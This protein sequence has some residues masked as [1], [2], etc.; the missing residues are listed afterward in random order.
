MLLEIH[1]NNLRFQVGDSYL[2]SGDIGEIL[3]PDNKIFKYN[4]ITDTFIFN[5]PGDYT[6]A[7]SNDT[8]KAF[9]NPPSDELAFRKLSDSKFNEIFKSYTLIKEDTNF[10]NKVKE[11]RYGVELWKYF[12]YLSIFL[13]IIE[14]V[15]SNQL[16]RRN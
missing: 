12:L 16:F 9:V 7:N 15:V 10:S 2:L 5:F 1:L 8:K 3:G 6:I 13:I 4:K 14:M 11:L